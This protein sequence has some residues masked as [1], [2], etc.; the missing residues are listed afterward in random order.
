MVFIVFSYVSVG[1]QFLRVWAVFGP[2]LGLYLGLESPGLGVREG[3]EI[4]LQN[5]KNAR[6]LI[7]VQER[8]PK[9]TLEYIVRLCRV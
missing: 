2:F 7:K 5:H 6:F 8:A 3:K 4:V 9:L 1:F